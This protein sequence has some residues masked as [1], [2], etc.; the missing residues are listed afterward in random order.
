MRMT[1]RLLLTALALAPTLA[2]PTGPVHAAAAPGPDYS[3][4]EIKPTKLGDSI[5]MLAGAG[6]NM[7]ILTGPDG[8]ILIDDQFAELSDKIKAAVAAVSDRPIRYLINTHWHG[9][10]TGG[11]ENF[12]KG[13]AIIVAHDNVRRQ[14]SVEHFMKAFN[15]QVPPSPR[16]ALPVITFNDSLNVHLNGEELRIFHVKN[17]HTDGD[18]IIHFANANVVHMGDTFFNGFYPFIDTQTGGSINGTIA[19]DDLV[20]AR[21]DENTKVIPGHGPLGTKA[22]LKAFRDML[23]GIRDG[24]A[25]QIKAGKSMEETVAAKPAAEFEAAWGGGFIKTDRF[26]AMVYEDLKGVR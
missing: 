2:L 13:G 18:A 3:K 1:T 26:V 16:A 15:S 4:V 8:V 20:L 12:S 6:G 7:A 19:A 25:K 17:A 9:D 24:V 22:Q 14:M 23:A 21:I 10:H 5:T 11:N